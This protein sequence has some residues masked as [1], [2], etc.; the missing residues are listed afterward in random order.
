MVVVDPHRAEAQR[1]RHAVGLVQVAG[2]DRGG[3]AVRRVVGGT[4]RLFLGA[5]A[6][7]GDH[8]PENLLLRNLHVCRH[9]GQQRRFQP[10][11]LLEDIAGRALAAMDQARAFRNA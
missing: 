2:P 4:Q 10:V 11:A 1:A 5:E 6:L 3:Q 9:V 7:G 8:R